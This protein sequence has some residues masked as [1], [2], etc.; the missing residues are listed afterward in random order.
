MRRWLL[1]LAL[2]GLAVPA[3]AQAPVIDAPSAQALPA[4]GGVLIDI[5]TPREIAATGRPEGAV[6]VPLQGDDMTFRAGFVDEVRAAAGGDPLRPVALIDANGRRAEFA[7]RL[8]ASQGFATLYVVGEG[9]LGSNLGP[10]WLRRGLP[11][12]R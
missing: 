10:G 9:M 3:A 8:L 1:A 4:A 2:L 5:R 6:T 11:V 12:E 7:A